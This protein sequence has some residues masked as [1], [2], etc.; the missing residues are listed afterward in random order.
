MSESILEIHLDKISPEPMSGCW[1][2]VGAV[3]SNG[4]GNIRRSGK[5]LQAHRV[6]YKISCDE[7]PE[8][9]HVLHKCDVRCCVNPEHLFLGTHAENMADKVKK[10]RQA[11]TQGVKN[12]CAKLTEIKVRE[13]RELLSNLPRYSRGE[14]S[15]KLVA[16]KYG[17][18]YDT[19][20]RIRNRTLWAHVE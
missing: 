19:L 17:I 2:W 14:S 15:A 1:L 11:K 8:G 16:K 20:N 9:F 3:T 6:S 13:I 4:Y 10:G 5:S 7:I 18:A 12:G